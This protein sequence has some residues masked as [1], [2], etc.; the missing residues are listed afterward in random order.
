MRGGLRSV[1][2]GV[3][4]GMRISVFEGRTWQWRVPCLILLIRMSRA[5]PEPWLYHLV[6][7]Q[8]S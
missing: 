1:M 7:S 8:R 3:V 4:P 6:V 5:E 2:L